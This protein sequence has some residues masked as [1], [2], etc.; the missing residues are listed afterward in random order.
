MLF[1][2]STATDSIRSL[3]GFVYIWTERCIDS[4][5]EKSPVLWQPGILISQ[6]IFWSHMEIFVKYPGCR[7]SQEPLGILLS[8]LGIFE[9]K[10][11]TA[12]E[13]QGFFPS[14]LTASLCSCTTSWWVT[15][16]R[17]T[18]PSTQAP[19]RQNRQD[20]VTKCWIILVKLINDRE[21]GGGGDFKTFRKV[22]Q[23]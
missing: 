12:R 7:G 23:G 22:F 5:L 16:W 13:L 1:K 14:L 3:S 9:K 2:K 4:R 8:S 20:V 11:G 21:G 19:S 10:I 17:T 15:S 18:S 6:G